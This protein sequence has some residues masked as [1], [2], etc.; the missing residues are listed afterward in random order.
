MQ[1]NV[2]TTLNELR[3]E[4]ARSDSRMLMAMAAMIGIAVATLGFLIRS[5]SFGP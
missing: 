2:N 1:A 3:A 5:A 4:S